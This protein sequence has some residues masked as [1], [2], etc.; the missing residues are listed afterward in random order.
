MKRIIRYLIESRILDDS[1][2]EFSDEK[3]REFIVAKV[4]T[5][6]SGIL[7]N[8]TIGIHQISEV[9]FLIRICTDSDKEITDSYNW[10]IQGSYRERL[11]ELRE[12]FE[13]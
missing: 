4:K 7:E 11:V 2:E 12:L 6:F 10:C 9:E 5:K 8:M 1:Y 13:K 3:G